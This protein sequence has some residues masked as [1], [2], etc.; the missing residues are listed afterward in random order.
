MYQKTCLR[1]NAERKDNIF[2]MRFPVQNI[3]HDKMQKYMFILLL[4]DLCL[5]MF[6]GFF[7]NQTG[8]KI[9]IYL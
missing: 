3:T 8:I 7:F 2:D 6:C 9:F 4:N 5:N 1:H